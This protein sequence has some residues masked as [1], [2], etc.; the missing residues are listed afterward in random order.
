MQQSDR[1]VAVPGWSFLGNV[2]GALGWA[3]QGVGSAGSGRRVS[4]A[5]LAARGP[6]PELR[7][8]RGAGSDLLATETAGAGSQPCFSPPARERGQVSGE[9][10][11]GTSSWVLGLEATAPTQERVP[12]ASGRLQRMAELS[13]ALAPRGA[14]MRGLWCLGLRAARC[15][16]ATD[17]PRCRGVPWLGG[18]WGHGP[19]GVAVPQ[20]P[21]GVR[22]AALSPPAPFHPRLAAGRTTDVI[23]LSREHP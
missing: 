23:A 5:V 3:V 14:G 22:A 6:S 1:W 7:C 16:G 8:H 9:C 19:P 17:C 12:S 21:P 18:C 13:N 11:G 2:T 20:Q 10:L 4:R 15:T